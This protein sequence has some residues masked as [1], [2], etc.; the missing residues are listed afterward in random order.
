M[1]A[2]FGQAGT[3]SPAL[4]ASSWRS[5]A[6]IM[7]DQGGEVDF[8]FPA[9]HVLGFGGVTDE[10]VD[11]GGADELGVL[12]H[13]VTPVLDPHLGKGPLHQILDRMGLAGGHDVVAGFGLLQHQPHRLHVVTGV[14]P[15]TLG[16]QVAQHDLVLQAEFDAGRGVGHLAG[17]ELQTTP[18]AL[19]VEQDPRGGVQPVGLAV[20]D[21]DVVPEHLGTPVRG[22]R[23][24]RGQLGLGGFADLAEHLRD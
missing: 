18:G 10:Q 17:H 13:V 7:L 3:G 14:T 22:A 16:V 23:V 19:M 9:Q 2:R 20:V 4:V 15:V 1:D 21:H 8:G 12:A 24:E 6:T 5:W 11:F